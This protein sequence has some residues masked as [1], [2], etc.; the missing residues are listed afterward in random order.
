MMSAESGRHDSALMAYPGGLYDLLM[1]ARLTEFFNPLKTVLNVMTLHEL[2]ARVDED[3]LSIGM[4]KP[5][6]RRLKSSTAK[7]LPASNASL[8]SKLKRFLSVGGGLSGHETLPRSRKGSLGEGLR[9]RKASFRV[10]FQHLIPLASVRVHQ[11][12]GSG[13]FGVVQRGV[14]TDPEGIAHQVAVK[15]LSKEHMQNNTI[16]FMKEYEVMQ[17]IEHPSIVKLFGVVLDA[18]RI[19]LITEL[20]ALRSLL[21]CLNEPSSRSSFHVSRLCEF[22]LQICQGMSYLE[23]KRL[24]H[25]DLA[26]RNILVFSKEVVKISDFGLSRAL[27]VGKD[28]Y[29]T[30]FN[31]NLKLP[32]AWC[33]PECINFLKFTSAS[34]VWAFSTA[35]WEM[36]SYGFQPWAGLTGKQILDA[37]DEPHSRRLERPPY[38]P[39]DYYRIMME[40]W[41]HDP[42]KRPTFARLYHLLFDAKPERVKAIALPNVPGHLA[43]FVGDI[44]TVLDKTEGENALWKGCTDDGKVGY[45]S[46]NNT[47][48]YIGNLPTSN[49]VVAFQRSSVRGSKNGIK[50]KIS[51][52]MISGPRGHVQHTGHVGVDGAY[53]GD[54][55]GFHGS[56]SSSKSAEFV[57]MPCLSRADS[58]LSERAPL[59]SSVSQQNRH[60]GISNRNP[61]MVFATGY[62][63]KS[64][65]TTEK[66]QQNHEYQSINEDDAG[67]LFSTPLDLGP[68]LMDEVFNELDS[69]LDSA[70]AEKNER[71]REILKEVKKSQQPLPVKKSEFKEDFKD[72]VISTLARHKTRS[73]HK[74]QQATVKPINAQ[75]EKTLE[76]AIAM[77]NALASKSM[78]ELDKR[79]TEDFYENS[80]IPSPLTPNSPS[81]KFSFWFPN[82]GKSVSSPKSERRHFSEEVKF[83]SGDIE[84]SLTPGA[85]DAYRTLIEG[86]S[87]ASPTSNNL[88]NNSQSSSPSNDSL[89]QQYNRLSL[90]PSDFHQK[91]NP[92]PLPPKSIKMNNPPPKRHVR[93]NPLIIT[94][95][96]DDGF[97]SIAE[98]N[99]GLD[100]TSISQFGRVNTLP[101]NRSSSLYNFNNNNNFSHFSMFNSLHHHNNNNGDDFE[102][103]I[104]CSMDALDNIDEIPKYSSPKH[105]LDIGNNGDE[106]SLPLVQY[107]QD[108]VSCEDLLD[109]H[110]QRPEDCDEVRIMKKVL[111][112]D[113][114][115][116]DEEAVSALCAT[117]WN[118]HHAIKLIKVKN[119]IKTRPT[120]FSDSELIETL[121]SFEWDVVKAV[122]ALTK[123]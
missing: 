13:E 87:R 37:I 79:G 80:P 36:F 77:A 52:D 93:K 55:S 82:V 94:D 48:A 6:I 69:S 46:P 96:S 75:D 74:R 101:N 10:P 116:D 106:D 103:A 99:Q 89:L 53:F 47:V 27:G 7:F 23:E 51:R 3:F 66:P 86:S 84:S 107:N 57:S 111:K 62:L 9:E 88:N 108:H 100:N 122:T 14:W 41:S 60:D 50:K 30:N 44:M 76:S 110:R 58:D 5:E 12:L 67:E 90:P 45:F 56:V 20:A 28:Y 113:M 95:E 39:K 81:K 123:I 118:V 63:R 35:L 70:E 49:S 24:I 32:I 61:K 17:S 16:V 120:K 42:I 65:N 91:G 1:D 59:I 115:Q 4:S 2:K 98:V 38:C 54:V 119:L 64:S 29:Q 11:S 22:S 104:A 71:I 112:R 34:D 114:I 43:Y 117:G 102:N 15:A 68:S 19:M 21:E 72:L 73:N 109:F 83:V 8:S 105:S 31:A 78:H 18:P 121:R 97:R 25:R 92:L 85:K 33:A 40:C 26:A